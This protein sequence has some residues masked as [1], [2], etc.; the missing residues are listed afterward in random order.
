MWPDTIAP[1]ERN[2]VNLRPIDWIWHVRG[3][4][5]L[6]A[7]LSRDEVFERLA[8]VLR[9]TGTTDD[10]TADTLVFHK[11]A[12]A[13]QD[14]LAVFDWGILEVGRGENGSVL[15]YHLTSR[16]LLFCFLAPLLFLGMA[17]LTV[18][19]GNHQKAPVEAVKKNKDRVLPLNPIDKAL[20]APA[21]KKP[22]GKDKDDK[23]KP[24]PTA[25]Y[26]FA[27]MFAT[28]YVVGRILEDRLVRRLF[29]RRLEG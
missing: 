20:G 4:L 17:Q 27:G 12:Q 16:A 1:V 3:S 5:A 10:R 7:E 25:G 24:S 28:L 8:P 18:F 22:D 6:S 19:I 15:R 11:K 26:I 13:A 9:T 21:P 14:K 29:R 23:K 2:V